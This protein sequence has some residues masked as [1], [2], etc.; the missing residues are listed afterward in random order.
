VKLERLWSRN[1]E[2]YSRGLQ[3]GSDPAYEELVRT[4]EDILAALPRID[5]WRPDAL[6]WT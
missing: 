1:R 6:L 3:F 5:G 2:A 4:Y